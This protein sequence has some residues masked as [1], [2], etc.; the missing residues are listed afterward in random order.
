MPHRFAYRLREE[1]YRWLYANI[2]MDQFNWDI[3]EVA[4]LAFVDWIRDRHTRLF[5]RG[6]RPKTLL[7]LYG[8][9]GLGKTTAAK[10]LAKFMMLNSG[11]ASVEILQWSAYI[12]DQ[13]DGTQLITPRWDARL[14]ILDDFDAR[15]PIPNSLNTWILDTLSGQLKMRCEQLGYPTIMVS[16]RDPR[17][18]DNFLGTSSSGDRNEDTDQSA[19][20]LMDLWFRNAYKYVQFTGKYLPQGSGSREK[21]DEI[22]RKGANIVMN[23]SELEEMMASLGVSEVYY[24]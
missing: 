24:E 11:V 3:Q 20:T 14:L 5:K 8:G 13:L 23:K 9:N 10:A 21:R 22:I 18:M 1:R 16:N 12:K 19:M 2:G 17:A 4:F 6:P 7:F 15:R